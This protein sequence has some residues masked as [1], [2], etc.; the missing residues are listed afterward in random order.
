ML[1]MRR[2]VSDK[3]RELTAG[4][5]SPEEVLKP[6]RQLRREITDERVY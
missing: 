4:I 6:V 1:F 3:V 5:F 2:V